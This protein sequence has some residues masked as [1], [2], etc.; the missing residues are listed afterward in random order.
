MLADGLVRATD[1]TPHGNEAFFAQIR[2][3]DPGDGTDVAWTL[4]YIQSRYLI[5]VRLFDTHAQ[6][7][8]YKKVLSQ[9]STEIACFAEPGRRGQIGYSPV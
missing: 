8:L 1:N 6:M 5:L 3:V 7:V 9:V 2:P 4:G